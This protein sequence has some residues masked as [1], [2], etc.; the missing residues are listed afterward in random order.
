MSKI[1]VLIVDDEIH[2][3]QTLADLI[4]YQDYE[5]FTAADGYE[6]IHMLKKWIPD[7][8][9]SDIM[10]PNLDGYGL[11]NAIRNKPQ[12][13]HIP[14]IFLTA[15]NG[16]E[17]ISESFI[18]GVDDFISKPFKIN[19]LVERIQAKIKRFEEIKKHTALLDFSFEAYVVNEFNNP[20]FG[21]L[22]AID[23]LEHYDSNIKKDERFELYNA[24]KFSAE[25]LNRTLSNIIAYQTTNNTELKNPFNINYSTEIT[26]CIS[27]TIE[28]LKIFH[29][30]IPKRLEIDMEKCNI[31]MNHSNTNLILFEI[32]DNALKFSEV[33]TNVKISGYKNKSGMYCIIIDD[34]GVGFETE[35]LKNIGALKQFHRKII[36][37]EGVGLGL[38]LTHEL[39]KSHGGNLE[40][41]SIKGEGTQVNIKIPIKK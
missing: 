35:D 37:Q 41:Y 13:S 17:E 12:T 34:K 21:I 16:A 20:L 9:V 3:R 28:K 27:D 1:K 26:V 31:K 36:K 33:S 10:M 15:K 23:F 40:I 4:Q 38:Y 30:E 32:L 7:I 24:I 11:L 18:K 25:K 6:A 19:V 22:S 29:K 8:I 39:I 14:F 5:V 2:I